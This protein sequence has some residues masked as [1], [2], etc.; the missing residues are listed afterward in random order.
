[1]F[2]SV[3]Y[4]LYAS[5]MVSWLK[6]EGIVKDSEAIPFWSETCVKPDLQFKIRSPEWKVTIPLES[7]ARKESKNENKM[8]EICRIEG[9]IWHGSQRMGMICFI[10]RRDF[11]NNQGVH[12]DDG[13]ERCVAQNN[14]VKRSE[15]AEMIQRDR[16]RCGHENV[17]ISTCRNCDSRNSN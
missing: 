13:R 16:T 8:I 15:V 1:M 4:F 5:L 7:V 11:Q 17:I 2:S 12:A 3:P 6:F 10:Y 9:Q 14:E